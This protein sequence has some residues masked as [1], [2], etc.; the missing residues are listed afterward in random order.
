MG[1]ALAARAALGT[2]G[3]DPAKFKADGPSCI[4]RPIR[5]AP[6]CL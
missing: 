5:D 3:G 6:D 1:M 4:Q 2:S